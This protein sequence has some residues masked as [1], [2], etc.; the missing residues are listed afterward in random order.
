MQVFENRLDFYLVCT[1]KTRKRSRLVGEIKS[2][3][4]DDIKTKKTAD[5]QTQQAVDFILIYC[6]N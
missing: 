3:L 4:A 6:Y 2:R 1:L 5:H